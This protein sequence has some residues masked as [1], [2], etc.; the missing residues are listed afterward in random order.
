MARCQWQQFSLYYIIM[1]TNLDREIMSQP[2][3]FIQI[4]NLFVSVSEKNVLHGITLSITSGTTHVLMGANGAGK[5]SIAHTI[6]GNPQ[7]KV[8]SGSVMYEGHSIFEMPSW[9]RA[10]KG[11]F[12]AFQ[13]PAAVQGLSI[14]SLL[15]EAIRARDVA[16]FSLLDYTARLEQAADLIGMSRTWLHRPLDA[17]FSG[18]ERKRLELLQLLVL[19]PKFVMLDELDSGLDVDMCLSVARVLAVYRQQCPQA[20]FL[21]ISHQKAFLDLLSADYV[22]IMRGGTIVRSGNSSLIDDVQRGGYEVW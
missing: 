2:T 18:G 1:K 12:L 15:K 3:P 7:Y 4:E 8:V 14:Y 5:S 11:I 20:S 13:N 17:G 22:H 21:V 10:R 16:S 9:Q 6:M 19:Q